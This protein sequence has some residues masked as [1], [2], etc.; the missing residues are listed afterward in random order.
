MASISRDRGTVLPLVLVISVVLGL[1][2]VAIADYAT[3]TLRLSTG[4]HDESA[5]IV[6][7]DSALR[8]AIDQVR[9]GAAPCIFGPGEL[10]LTTNL[11]V[12]GI[13]A[14]VSCES[15]YGPIDAV[16][17]WALVLTG[18]AGGGE[19]RVV[20]NSNGRRLV[21]GPAWVSGVEASAF[22]GVSGGGEL[23]VRDGPLLYT[24]P[25]LPPTTTCST[26]GD[27][28]GSAVRFAPA[29]M[30]GPV[31]LDNAW[32]VQPSFDDPPLAT[33]LN[34]ATYPTDPQL[35]L[36]ES[37]P[38]KCVVVSPG[39]YTKWPPEIPPEWMIASIDGLDVYFRT[40]DY[41]FAPVGNPT[42]DAAAITIDNRDAIAGLPPAGLAPTV[43]VN[44]ACDDAMVTDAEDPLRQGF[45][46]TFYLGTQA[47]LVIGTNGALEIMPRAQSGLDRTVND[48]SS[49]VTRSAIVSVQ[50]ICDA[51][52][53]QWCDNLDGNRN[54]VS[55]L[56]P[57]SL[58]GFVS[59]PPSPTARS[60]IRADSTSAR[61]VIHGLVY[62]PQQQVRLKVATHA[63]LLGGLLTARADLQVDAARM[64]IDRP[65][66]S[67]GSVPG[68]PD[69]PLRLVASASY[70]G[71]ITSMTA[72]VLF[73]PSRPIHERVEV[74]SW[75]VC[76]ASC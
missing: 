66:S 64:L 20:T 55:N 24:P 50:A 65:A 17:Y 38:D 8:A 36:L 51:S 70:D 29:L 74:K 56:L 63:A 46:A 2:V 5:R 73:R 16:R 35:Q 4:A 32:D 43:D 41:Y 49:N 44:S 1:A 19:S 71:S 42:I 23:E 14:G 3:T 22:S 48:P 11:E 21:G 18:E 58:P 15:I 33:A 39:R 69:V 28:I 52:G 76:A 6:A 27:T 26:T 72:L 53:Q 13:A 7:A 37:G 34:S 62:T 30:Y 10:T 61:L 75:R 40:G 31:C 59:D 68:A 45:G 25:P 47:H 57:S 67:D 54:P 60:I 9:A 12:N